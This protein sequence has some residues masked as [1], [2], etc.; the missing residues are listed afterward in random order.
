M[1]KKILG[2]SFLLMDNYPSEL[3]RRPSSVHVS[4]LWST[5]R[6]PEKSQRENQLTLTYS[7]L[8]EATRTIPESHLANYIFF[9]ANRFQALGEMLPRT[10]HIGS[11]CSSPSGWRK[12]AVLREQNAKPFCKFRSLFPFVPPLLYVMST[13]G[14][15]CI[16]SG[17]KAFQLSISRGKK[18]GNI[19]ISI[20]YVSVPNQ[21]THKHA[22]VTDKS[23]LFCLGSWTALPCSQPAICQQRCPPL[24]L[25]CSQ[26]SRPLHSPTSL[27][28]SKYLM[29]F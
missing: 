21:H 28:G 27:T 17:F 2:E 20:H 26:L 24:P 4:V 6:C 19:A 15:F 18:K 3:N 29:S 7:H 1:W 11:L 8:L 14:H 22:C 13:F 12:R 16:A 25:L 9:P 5:E 10:S 23:A